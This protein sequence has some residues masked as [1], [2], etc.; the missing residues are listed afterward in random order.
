MQN[1]RNDDNNNTTTKTST[2]DVVMR[3]F[4]QDEWEAEAKTE[5]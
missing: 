4:L 2:T 5:N 3:G 1:E